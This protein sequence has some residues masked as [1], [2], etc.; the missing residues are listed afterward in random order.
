MNFLV[1]GYF[2]EH[3]LYEDKAQTFVKSLHKYEVPH[4]VER[5]PN[6]G[7]WQKNTSYKPTFIKRM[8]KQFPNVNIV[9][10][11]VDAKF[12]GYPVLFD[13][14]DCDVAAY[15]Y[16]GKEYRKRNWEPEVLSGTLYF[17]NCSKV[18]ELVERWEIRCQSHTSIWDQKHLAVILGD[19]FE[20]LP[21]EYCKICD[22]MKE[23]MEPIIVHYQASREVRAKKGRL[24]RKRTLNQGAAV[25]ESFPMAFTAFLNP[26]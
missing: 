21:G 13:N 15:V 5:V 1:V 20:R 14:L 12:F 26:N 3:T 22:K 7:S 2:T 11:D 23:V 10:V 6:L 16:D 25:M 18:L 8:L 17:R 19:D 24:E 9:Y 4:Y